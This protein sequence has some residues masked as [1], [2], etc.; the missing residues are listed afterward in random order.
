MSPGINLTSFPRRTNGMAPAL[1][2]LS[3]VRREILRRSAV[4]ILSSRLLPEVACVSMQYARCQ[5]ADFTFYL[6]MAGHPVFSVGDIARQTGLSRQRV[7]QLAIAGRI[8]AKRANPNGKQH[9]FYDSEEFAAWRKEKARQSAKPPVGQV[10]RAYR[11]SR[12]RQEKI[13]KLR[14]ILMN[15]TEV[16]AS[17]KETALLYYRC[18]W[19]LWWVRWW[20]FA[21]MQI[22]LL[23]GIH[24]LYESKLIFANETGPLIALESA[25]ERLPTSSETT[26]RNAQSSS[27]ASAQSQTRPRPHVRRRVRDS[28]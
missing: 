27:N 9:R 12:R 25:I 26:P 20:N 2:R 4:S 18:L 15:Q 5:L 22:P 6:F 8:P 14:E 28:Y 16:S 21:N 23:E 24:A 13:E 7:W 19:R 10:R 1:I 11:I 17:D 3:K